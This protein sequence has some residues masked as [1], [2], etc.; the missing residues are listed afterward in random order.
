V[1]TMSENYLMKDSP[2]TFFRERDVVGVSILTTSKGLDIKPTLNNCVSV[3]FDT[4]VSP[5]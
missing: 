5:R 3:H 4:V 2:I 1:D